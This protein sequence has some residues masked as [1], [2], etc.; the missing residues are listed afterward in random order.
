MDDPILEFLRYQAKNYNCRVC[1]QKYKGS[2]LR[3]VGSH[4]NK[5][6][7]QVT[8]SRCGDS[9]FLHVEFAG[10]IVNAVAEVTR[11]AARSP[12]DAEEIEGDPLT[13]DEVLDAHERLSSFS[14][15]LTDLIT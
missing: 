14:G 13:T 11:V 2:Q 4:Q 10:S 7:V 1:G 5:L 3:K 12:R 8:C 6:V 9:F 15:K